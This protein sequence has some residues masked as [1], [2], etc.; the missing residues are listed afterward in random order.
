MTHQV[1][2]K[3][4]LF[5]DFQIFFDLKYNS[6]QIEHLINLVLISDQNIKK[7]LQSNFTLRLLVNNLSSIL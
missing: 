7:L 1:K 4:Y 2:Q 5:H 3:Y 6:L